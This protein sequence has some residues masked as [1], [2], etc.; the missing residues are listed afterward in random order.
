MARVQLP[1]P[2]ADLRWTAARKADVVRAIARGELSRADAAE[3]YTLSEDELTSWESRYRVRGLA[4]LK[5]KDLDR[6]K[7]RS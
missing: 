2:D 1:T 4:A 3:R 7:I 5:V 6:G